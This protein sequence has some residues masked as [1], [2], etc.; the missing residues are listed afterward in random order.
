MNEYFQRRSENEQNLLELEREAQETIQ[1][2]EDVSVKLVQCEGLQNQI[3]HIED[4]VE[5]YNA[6]INVKTDLKKHYQGE[7]Q[8][9]KADIAGVQH[10]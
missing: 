3:K 4:V 10:P 5:Q 9:L 7:V 8:K 2:K 1:Q 6:Q